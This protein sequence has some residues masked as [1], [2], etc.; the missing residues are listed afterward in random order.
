LSSI[1]KPEISLRSPSR[2][3]RTRTELDSLVE[4]VTIYGRKHKK[5]SAHIK[6]TT[7]QNITVTYFFYLISFCARTTGWAV[8]NRACIVV[9]VDYCIVQLNIGGGRNPHL[10]SYVFRKFNFDRTREQNY[11]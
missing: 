10:V 9:I 6:S 2:L 1:K 3:S 5:V 7:N 4:A 8:C 11:R